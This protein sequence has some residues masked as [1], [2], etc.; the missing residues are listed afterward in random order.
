MTFQISLSLLLLIFDPKDGHKELWFDL[1]TIEE[2][3]GPRFEKLPRGYL[4]AGRLKQISSIHR[5]TYHNTNTGMEAET[6]VPITT[7]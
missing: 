3:V 6:A 5:Y 1:A 7:C 4:H 2:Y